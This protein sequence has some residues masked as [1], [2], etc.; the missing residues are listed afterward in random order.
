MA[1]FD[2]YDYLE[3][4]LDSKQNGA[5]SHR[6]D[7]KREHKR[8]RDR[9]KEKEKDK[10]HRRRS[11]SRS[12]SFEREKER[13][14]KR[15]RSRSRDRKR[16][17]SHKSHSRSRRR[18][19]PP[20]KDSKEREQERELEGLE[21]DARTVFAYNLALKAGEREIYEFFSRAGTVQDVRIIID[22]Y[23]K[24][25]KGFAYV[26]FSKQEEVLKA[27]QLTGQM[28]MKQA[29]MVKVSEAEKN[30]AWEA[31][32]QMQKTREEAQRAILEGTSTAS[33]PVRVYVGNLDRSVMESDL[34]Q[35]F[36][37]FGEVVNITVQRDAAGNS[38]GYAY[39]LFTSASGASKAV[40]TLNGIEIVSGMKLQ[41]NVAQTGV[42]DGS[43]GL[44]PGELDED[45]ENGGMRLSVQAKAALMNRLANSAGMEPAITFPSQNVVQQTNRPET[46]SNPLQHEQ[47]VLGP[48]SPKPTPCLL[49][50][51]MFNPEEETE[52]DW[53]LEIKEDVGEECRKNG[54]VLHIYVDKYS[55]GFVYVKMDS[56][57]SA[58]RAMKALHG[59][60]FAGRQIVAEFQFA[61]IYS[62]HFG[63]G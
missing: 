27:I 9:E 45:G 36:E 19:S 31:Q 33:G 51:G 57:E 16:S 41:V 58:Q 17:R 35:I 10:K 13:R 60:W 48:S 61:Q 34:K 25:S 12:R 29:V 55:K 26:E 4:Q 37:P 49:L 52:L 20:P 39:V 46:S 47:G 30:Q 22:R 15:S 63:L 2:E 24:K 11:R 28:L 8:D 43:G 42:G 40:Q 6:N 5:T 59:R 18:E 50:K 62:K 56:V 32:Q 21:K 1:D 54:Q 23:T 3:Q 44:V 14:R 7:E 53:D 38:V